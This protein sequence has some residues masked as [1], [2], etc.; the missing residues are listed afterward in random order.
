MT[1]S[2]TELCTTSP[3]VRS[4]VFYL[5]NPASGTNS[6]TVTFSASTPATGGSATYYNVNQASPILNNGANQGSSST[7][8][9]S[10][11]D[12][13]SYN[14]VLFGHVAAQTTSS[15]TLADNSKQTNH[16]SKTGSYTHSS[17]TYNCAAEGS[18][19][20]VTSGSV[21]LTWTSSHSASWA[22]ILILLCPTPLPTQET[23][24]VVF[25]GSSNT[26]NLNNLAWAIDASASASATVTVTIELYN[27][28]LNQYPTSGNGYQTTTLTSSNVTETQ[29]INSNAANFKDNL[30]NWQVCVTVTASVSS[31]FT[32]NLNLVRYSPGAAVYSLNL[33]EEWTN[34]NTT[35]LLHPAL[36]IYG[37][38][39]GSSNL[40][41]SV[42]TIA[43]GR[44]SQSELISG[45]NN[46]SINSYLT[47]GSTT[48]A[49][50]F[51]ATNGNSQNTWKV[52]STLIRPESNQDIFSALQNPAATVAVE[53]LQNGTM[54]WLGQNMT[55]TTQTIPVPPVPV[56][57]LHV[58]ETINGVNQQVPFQVEDWAS[59]YTVPLGLTNNATVFGNRQMVVF[60]VNTHVSAFTL[61]W[62]GSSQAVQTPLAYTDTCFTK[63]DTT[64][65]V[66]T[67]GNLTLI[68][69]SISLYVDGFNSSLNSWTDFGTSPYINGA[70][71]NY[72]SDSRNSDKEGWFTFQQLPTTYSQF[73]ATEDQ[74]IGVWCYFRL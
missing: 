33:E 11:S 4:Y 56:K 73:F 41:V 22:V 36:C 58:N 55:M 60:L 14:A 66:L 45:W 9:C 74:W 26:L 31:S 10:L 32:V 35:T 13:Q 40:A 37:G 17:T 20:S 54:I 64:N 46:M 42:G 51:S 25:S 1:S 34:L 15:L 44:F 70:S 50:K 18:D 68:L 52:A 27:Y 38:T 8:S 39:M 49:I 59:D 65:G 23:C 16:W 53:L 67:N 12:S 43:H 61:W 19:K 28:N 29:T 72:I 7:Q 2:Y 62:N 63:D 57:A 6:I 30:G 69:P 71:N 3:E 5:V 48:F 21:S 24:Q 47:S